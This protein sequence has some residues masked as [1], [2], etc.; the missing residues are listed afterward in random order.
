MSNVEHDPNK[1]ITLTILDNFVRVLTLYNDEIYGLWHTWV[2][3][4][5]VFK[6]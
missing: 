6:L 3:L 5:F 2:N 1:S 4:F